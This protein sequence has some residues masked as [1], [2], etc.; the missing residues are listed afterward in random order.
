[1]IAEFDKFFL[2]HVFELELHIDTKVNLSLTT[3]KLKHVLQVNTVVLENLD[4]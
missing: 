3:I 2:V 4:D 1:M